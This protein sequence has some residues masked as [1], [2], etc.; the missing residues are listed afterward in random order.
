MLAARSYA[1]AGDMP[2]AETSLRSVLQRE[3]DRFD[4][5]TLLGQVYS[6]QRKLPQA[7]K[8]FET[9]LGRDPNSV[10]ANTAIGVLWQFQGRNAEAEK[11]YEKTLSLDSRAA[12]ASNNLAWLLVESN[13]NL[14]RAL[15]LAQTARQQMPDNPDVADTLGW[16]FVK[17]QMAT[18]AIPVLE[19]SAKMKANDPVIH[20][21]LGVAYRL[22][23]KRIDARRS[24]SRALELSGSFPGSDEARKMMAA[25]TGT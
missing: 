15:E 18:S 20:F 6:V 9:I 19:S 12:V 14:D 5:Y 25:L 8:E 2:K 7:I 13:R 24:L 11:A 1:S 3:P 10:V 4:A 16:I 17:K 21:H 22:A 23:G